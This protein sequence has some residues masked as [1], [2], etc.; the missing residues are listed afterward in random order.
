MLQWKALWLRMLCAQRVLCAKYGSFSECKG[1]VK[2]IRLVKFCFM[3][4]LVSWFWWLNR[5]RMGI[6]SVVTWGDDCN[7]LVWSVCLFLL[8]YTCS[9][10]LF[11]RIPLSVFGLGDSMGSFGFRDL[12]DQTNGDSCKNWAQ[13]E[14]ENSDSDKHRGSSPFNNSPRL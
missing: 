8:E 2:V 12:G 4:S 3:N 11:S 6:R 7:W 1:K 10:R 9:G 14:M 5:F 13:L